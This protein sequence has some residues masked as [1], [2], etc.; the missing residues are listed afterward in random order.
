MEKEEEQEEKKT[1]SSSSGSTNISPILLSPHLTFQN[2]ITI[3]IRPSSP[4]PQSHPHPHPHPHP[5]KFSIHLS[6]LHSHTPFFLQSLIP[7]PRTPILIPTLISSRM[8]RREWRWEFENDIKTMEGN[9]FGDEDGKIEIPVRVC[10][11]G[12]GMGEVR[13]FELQRGIIM[14]AGREED[15]FGMFVEWLYNGIGGWDLHADSGSSRV[16]YHISIL[17]RLWLFAQKLQVQKCMDDCIKCIALLLRASQADGISGILKILA[18]VYDN[19]EKQSELR[20]FL[21]DQCARF[22]DPELV[23]NGGLDRVPRMALLDLVGRLRG[24][25]MIAD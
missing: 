21:I 6:L 22:L 17:A 16:A 23:L 5:Q 15:V 13:Q 11:P 14:D 7:I 9:G 1:S 20:C 18:W 2:S 19:T 12:M 24:L 10:L 25:L 8:L 3:I 4:S